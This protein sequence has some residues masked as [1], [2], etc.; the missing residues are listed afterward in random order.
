M[1]SSLSGKASKG[2]TDALEKGTQA[3]NQAEKHA[4]QRL[5]EALE[6]T[7]PTQASTE[8]TSRSQEDAQ[9]SKGDA[10]GSRLKVPGVDQEK[11]LKNLQM[12]WTSITKRTAEATK[13]IK[14][15]VDTERARLEE[16]FALR[17]KGFYKRDPSLPLDREALSDADVTYVTDRIIIM[18][19]PAMQSKDFPMIT[20]E[21]KLAAVGHMLARRH[22]GRF[23]VYN[24]SEVDYDTS[25]LDDQVLTFSFPGSPSPPLGLLLKL[26]ISLEN[27]MKA[28]ER[29][30]AVVHCL[31]GKGRSSMVV[32]SFLCWMGEAGFGNINEAIEYIAK[33]KRI[34]PM[35]LTIPSQRRYAGYFKNVLDGVKPSQPPLLLKRIIMS[36][37]PKF[38]KAPTTAKELS[39]PEGA[40]EEPSQDDKSQMGCAPYLQIF[41]AGKLIYT[42]AATV[43]P[44]Q[45]LEDLPFVTV[46]DGAI[47]FNDINL[48][49]S[50]DILV[51]ARHLTSDN[52]RVSMFRWVR[53]YQEQKRDKRCLFF[54]FCESLLFSLVCLFQFRYDEGR[55]FIPATLHLQTF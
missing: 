55:L 49:L 38:A 7:R 50:G 12:G 14:D 32:A 31:T 26:L 45:Q 28:D 3:F 27:W 33:C 13:D 22:D 40:Q 42:T 19:H 34:E 6:K 39:N 17:K 46:S 52:K 51:R 16:N 2:L 4:S 23:L 1:W 9:A 15:L 5:A 10:I 37:A 44:D 43:K 21:R 47:P 25:V 35:M 53:S 54:S 30:V 24:L 29:N 20:A 11:V 36:E 48:T 8:D 18:G 41:K